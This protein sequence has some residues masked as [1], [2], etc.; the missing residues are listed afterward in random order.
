[1]APNPNS[2]ML[3]HTSSSLLTSSHELCPTYHAT[4]TAR[5]ATL[6]DADAIAAIYN[7]GIEDRMATFETRLRTPEEI[8]VWFDGRHPIVIVEENQ[9]ILAFA[10]TSSYRPRA[11]Y[12]GIAEISIYVARSHRGRGAGRLALEE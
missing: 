7:Q 8:R 3:F 6:A 4:M 12:D 5:V 10:A 11:C 1:M 9:D 2:H